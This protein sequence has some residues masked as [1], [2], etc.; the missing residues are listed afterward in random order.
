MKMQ[1]KESF[2]TKGKLIEEHN[3]LL[4]K[5]NTFDDREFLLHIEY[6][7]T[8]YTSHEYITEI[9]NY[10]PKLLFMALRNDLDDRFNDGKRIGVLEKHKV[11]KYKTISAEEIRN[12]P[13]H[14]DFRSASHDSYIPAS[15]YVVGNLSI[16]S[17]FFWMLSFGDNFYHFTNK[18]RSVLNILLKNYKIDEDGKDNLEIKTKNQYYYIEHIISRYNSLRYENLMLYIINTLLKKGAKLKTKSN[19]SNLLEI[20]INSLEHQIDQSNGFIF[21]HELLNFLIKNS[22][23]LNYKIIDNLVNFLKIHNGEIAAFKIKSNEY[24][25]NTKSQKVSS[26][27]NTIKEE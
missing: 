16:L 12:L 3:L 1:L 2:L 19:K 11:N 9:I 7:E 23:P 8:K 26:I 5:C 27:L 4:E 25:K 13:S 20:F 15:G 22:S 14:K 21:P 17:Y 18:T 10:T 6:L 24:I